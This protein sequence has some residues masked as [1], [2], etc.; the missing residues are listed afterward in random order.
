MWD[1]EYGVVW[2]NQPKHK[3][4]HRT[5]LSYASNEPNVDCEYSYA[6]IFVDIPEWTKRGKSNSG[7]T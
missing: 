5:Y 1:H 2:L 3:E 6:A 4:P 7:A